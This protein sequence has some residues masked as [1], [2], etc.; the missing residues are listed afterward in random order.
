MQYSACSEDIFALSNSSPDDHNEGRDT[1][2]GLL[3]NSIGGDLIWF[4][5]LFVFIF[6]FV[7]II[8][9]FFCLELF[10]VK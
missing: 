8:F 2:S 9:F 1:E 10:I 3:W 4:I 7:I 5:C 6:V